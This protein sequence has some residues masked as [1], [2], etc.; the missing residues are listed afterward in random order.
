MNEY[1]NQALK[2]KRLPLRSPPPVGNKGPH[3]PLAES[4]D[5][6]HQLESGSPAAAPHVVYEK[7]WGVLGSLLGAVGAKLYFDDI[8]RIRGRST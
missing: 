8:C 5:S 2:R 6:A 7:R 3:T 1:S 4:R